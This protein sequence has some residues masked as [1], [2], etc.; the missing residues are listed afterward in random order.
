M[1]NIILLGLLLITYFTQSQTLEDKLEEVTSKIS[2]NLKGKENYNIAVYPFTSLK[3]KESNLSM[4]IFGEFH[5]SLK[6]KEYNF[7][8]MDRAT[9]ESYLAEHKLNSEG[10]IDYNTAKK[11]GKLIAADA[12]V[13]SKV[14][15]FG[16]VIN[17]VV[18]VTDTQTGEII[19]FNSEKIPIDYDMAQF[20]EI[21]NWGEKRDKA[22]VNKSQNINCNRLN[23]GN[24]CFFN[25]TSISHEVHLGTK[26]N[27]SRGR[28]KKLVL[29][30]NSKSCFKDLA[31]GTHFFKIVRTDRPNIAGLSNIVI[32][33]K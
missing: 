26:D 11:F 14:Y 28:S 18:K 8:V 29:P 19:S 13:T 22:A 32:V 10:L 7:K 12:Y 21:K 5:T 23:V 16:S 33:N 15:V 30:P 1:K 27:Y 31:V 4:H 25:N 9:I 17:F 2:L 24:Y 6:A 20:L 3:K